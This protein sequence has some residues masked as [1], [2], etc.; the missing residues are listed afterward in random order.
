QIARCSG[1][2]GV[3]QTDDRAYS[4]SWQPYTECVER[5]VKCFQNAPNKCTQPEQ[6]R[7]FAESG[8]HDPATIGE[9]PLVAVANVTL[10]DQLRQDGNMATGD[11]VK[12]IS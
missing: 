2:N 3:H 4:R 9:L 6:S 11:H 8:H 1:K 12:R 10:R 7:D 5:I